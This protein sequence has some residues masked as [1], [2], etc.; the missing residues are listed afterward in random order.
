L[1]FRELGPCLACR[2]F[3]ILFLIVK[4]VETGFA[5]VESVEFVQSVQVVKIVEFVKIGRTWWAAG[6]RKWVWE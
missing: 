4:S 6:L 3:V 5:L 2:V 1:F